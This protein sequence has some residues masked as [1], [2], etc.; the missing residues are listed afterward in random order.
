MHIVIF[1]IYHILLFNVCV[2]RTIV[3]E[4]INTLQ[5]NQLDTEIEFNKLVHLRLLQ[6]IYAISPKSQLFCVS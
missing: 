4:N 6:R 5:M 2:H 1:Y 3:W